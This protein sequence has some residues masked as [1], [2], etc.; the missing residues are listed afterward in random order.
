M[1]GGTAWLG[2]GV[3]TLA[4]SAGHEVVCVA[5]GTSGE[6][7]A[8]ASLVVADRD[9]DDA[10]SPVAGERW[11]VVLDVA[12]QPG[13]VRRAARDLAD[14]GH[15]VYVS[16]ISVYLNA[17][18]PGL[19]ESAPLKDALES[20]VMES[21]ETY[22]EAKVACEQAV[23]EA[24]AGRSTIVRAGLV[25]GPGDWSDRTTYWPHRFTLGSP[26]LVPDAP[27]Q[28][29]ATVDGRDLTAFLLHAGEHRVDGTVNVVGHVVPLAE[30]LD[31][32]ARVAGS[33]G[34]AVAASEEWL[35]AHGVGP[36]F[37]PRSLPVWL[38]D[39][40]RF[41]TGFRSD[42]ALA[43]GL[44]MR[45]LEETLAD[46][47]AWRS[48]HPDRPWRSGLSLDEENVLLDELT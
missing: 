15:Y 5:R 46:G 13:H 18:Q 22:G 11:D 38:G 17:A 48:E 4:A 47:L 19:D 41:L 12:S 36:W 24:F 39:E 9:R 34:E 28:P 29:A 42:A 6:V 20:D 26:V 37:G 45:P 3:A 23:R 40:E 44:V 35:T 14:V 16:T 31:T 10:L 30:H 32:A 25:G 33:T 1:L 7:A 2:R 43:A 8:G 27:D 21:M